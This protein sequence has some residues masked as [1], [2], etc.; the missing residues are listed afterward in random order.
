M[1]E[2][3][4]MQEDDVNQ[5]VSNDRQLYM[6]GA[7]LAGIL[8]LQ[9]IGKRPEEDRVTKRESTPSSV[10][11]ARGRQ[12]ETP[13]QIPPRGWTDILQRTYTAI[14]EDRIMAL[15]AGSTY[16]VLL[17]IF[18]AIAAL[19]AIYGLF[20]DPSAI[21]RQLGALQGILPGGAMD[22]LGEEL[23]RLTS[24][25]NGTLNFALFAGVITALWS[26]NSGVKS[27]FESLNQVYGEKE[28]RSFF[29][30]TLV[31]LAFT[32]AAIGL[33]VVALSAVVVLPVKLDNLGLSSVTAV[34]AQVARW[35]LLF[36]VLTV[37]LAF[38]YRFGPN[39]RE[40]KWRWV[41]WGS[42]AAAL[43]WIVASLLF[44]WY[45]GSFGSFNKTYGS[46]G[47]IVGFMV[48][49]WISMIVVLLGAELD[50]EMEHQ[51]RRDTTTG[52]P[53]PRGERGAYMADT[54]GAAQN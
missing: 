31:T 40:P 52:Q 10:T 36:V 41:T 54:V 50:A 8:L 53:R 17:S 34:A 48:W 3:V 21:G 1:V 20:A 37:A 39:R 42:A 9:A 18:P 5:W 25:S 24:Q 6:L 15:A 51:T 30:L 43:L 7:T 44:S 26:A 45:A 2:R 16:Y 28:T 29:K 49:I 27:L 12:A 14:S 33:L 22:V 46:L 35:P 11:T 4:P 47:A 38:V 32:L 23:K 19:V 13:S